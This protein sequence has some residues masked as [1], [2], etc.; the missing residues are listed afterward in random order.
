MVIDNLNFVRSIAPLKYNSPLIIN[1]DRMI[2][3]P[4]SLQGFQSIAWRNSKI[5]EPI[6]DI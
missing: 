5:G 6:R 1:P 2:A 3:R 4:I